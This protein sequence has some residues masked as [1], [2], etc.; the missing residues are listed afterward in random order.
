MVTPVTGEVSGDSSAAG[1][2][3]E[4]VVRV[5]LRG[6]CCQCVRAAASPEW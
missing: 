6:Y 3:E 2:P 5:T 4:R 1:L